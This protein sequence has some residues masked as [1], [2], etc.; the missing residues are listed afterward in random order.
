MKFFK[1]YRNWLLILAL[2]LVFFMSY[3]PHIYLNHTMPLHAN[4]WK[5]LTEAKRL[6]EGGYPTG[7]Y[8]SLE[9]GFTVFL[10]FLKVIGFN[11][12][13]YHRFLA[14]VF[15]CLGAIILFYFIRRK[16]NFYT[17][18]LAMLFFAGMPSNANIEGFTFF[19]P[20]TFAI[21]LIYLFFM[22]FTEG[23]EQNNVKKFIGSFLIAS[24]LVLIHPI[25]VTFMIPI[26][27][28]YLL[29]NKEF[30]FR[31][32]L[33]F[34]ISCLIPLL[35]LPWSIWFLWEGGFFATIFKILKLFYFKWAWIGGAGEEISYFFPG[36]YGW[37]PIILA[38]VGIFFV[39]KN[40]KMKIFLIWV[41]TIMCLVI[42]YTF[43]K[44]TLFAN[45]QRLINYLMLGLIPLSAAG[46]YGILDYLVKY[47]EKKLNKQIIFG[48][49]VFL[50][51]LLSAD[52]LRGFSK[53]YQN[54]YFFYSSIDKYDYDAY[55]YLDEFD[56]ATVLL[57]RRKSYAFQFLTKHDSAACF[58]GTSLCSYFSNSEKVS[59]YFFNRYH[60]S[61]E[62]QKNIVEELNASYI[63]IPFNI[64]CSW[65]NEIYKN[66]GVY[67]YEVIG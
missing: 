66:E 67:V 17:G 57:I 36:L 50:I 58:P 43:F 59:Q 11:F 34:I 23:V 65:A 21:P 18:L 16:T 30:I 54:S 51:L 28:I 62:E 63:V 8:I 9:V 56:K 32:K 13:K 40:K 7:N 6:L 45:Y 31:N 38:M 29:L 53:D 20:L 42:M 33:I 10:A 12:I 19:I 49:I 14:P 39:V 25:S 35:V 60:L 15:A 22:L 3:R 55:Q 24:L 41:L 5:Q 48:I 26:L 52:V 47:L 46:A 64:K 27:F 2:L 44:F 4:E 61:C 37:V 1:D